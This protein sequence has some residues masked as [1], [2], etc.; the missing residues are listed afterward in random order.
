MKRGKLIVIEGAD[1]T[2][3]ATQSKLLL[4]RLKKAGRKTLY[5]DFPRYGRPSAYF[6]EQ[7][8]LGR[9]GDTHKFGAY[10]PAVFYAFDRYFAAKQIRKA[11]QKGI[12]IVCNRYTTS[13]LAYQGSKLKSPKVRKEFIRWLEHL[14]YDIFNLPQADLTIILNLERRLSKKLLKNKG[15][16]KY[17]AGKRLDLHE[18]ND[19]HQKNTQKLYLAL[20]RRYHYPVITCSQQDKLLDKQSIAEKIWKIVNRKI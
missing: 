19:K 15:K 11:L 4:A 10:I 16:R 3:K 20:A 18:K 9:F 13:S 8:L 1:A 7:Y 2:G 14:E 12:I 5:L 17:L 6:I